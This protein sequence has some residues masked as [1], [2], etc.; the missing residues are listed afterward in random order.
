MY[1]YICVC[2]C[3]IGI[4]IA[5]ACRLTSISPTFCR[6]VAR[7]GRHKARKG[8]KVGKHAPMTDNLLHAG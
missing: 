3:I 1:V 2:V 5:I 4:V 7:D 6:G 8:C